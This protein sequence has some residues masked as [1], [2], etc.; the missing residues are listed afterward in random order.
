[1]KL[2]LYVVLFFFSLNLY[3]DEMLKPCPDSPNCYKTSISYNKKIMQAKNAVSEMG[4]KIVDSN[5]D[6][7][8]ALFTSMFFKFVDD[9]E[10]KLTENHLHIRSSSRAGYY[11][12][13]ANKRRINQFI[14]LVDNKI[15]R[16]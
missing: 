14:G 11:D 15:S 2:L 6:Y 4:G 16:V 10:L 13:G 8:H 9:F 12:F 3:G 5:N 1:M 7:I